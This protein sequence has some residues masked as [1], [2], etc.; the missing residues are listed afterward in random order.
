MIVQFLFWAVVAAFV[1]FCAACLH[2]G[3]HL[4]RQDRDLNPPPAPV[5]PEE[6][7]DLEDD[8]F[9]EQ[10]SAWLDEDVHLERE[11]LADTGELQRLYE[12]PYPVARLSDTG[13]L[14][15]LALAGN[16]DEIA[17]QTAAYKKEIDQA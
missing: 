4:G 9:A 12:R 16:A 6:D 5:W 15:A 11:R 13:E 8:K 17:A 7:S 3:Y 2:I 14:R 10:L 1:G